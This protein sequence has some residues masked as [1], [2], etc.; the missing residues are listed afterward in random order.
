[1]EDVVDLFEL[2]GV[3]Y[4]RRGQLHDRIA[5]VVGAADDAAS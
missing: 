5:A 2:L 4:Q 1:V 3:R